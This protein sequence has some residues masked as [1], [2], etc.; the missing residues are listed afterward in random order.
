LGG[1]TY[2]SQDQGQDMRIIH[3]KPMKA[4]NS[5]STFTLAWTLAGRGTILSF[6]VDFVILLPFESRDRTVNWLW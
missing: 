2:T 4:M 3:N 6:F 5:L 1:D